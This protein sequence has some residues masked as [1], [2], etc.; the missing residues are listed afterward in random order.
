MFNLKFRKKNR[1]FSSARHEYCN[2]HTGPL[3]KKYRLIKIEDVCIRKVQQFKFF[4][5]LTHKDFPAYFNAISVIQV[6]DIHNSK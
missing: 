3:F 2:V 4:Y 1:A 5:K 6:G